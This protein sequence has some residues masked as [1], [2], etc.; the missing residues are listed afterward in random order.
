VSSKKSN[1]K[2]LTTYSFDNSGILNQVFT[3]INKPSGISS[4]DV[5]RK[6][7]KQFDTSRMG[8]LGTLD[9]LA[10]GV[11]AVFIGKGTKIIPYFEEARKTYIVQGE[12]G[13]SSD[14]YDITG[15]VQDGSEYQTPSEDDFKKAITSFLGEQWQIQPAFSA[16]KID[17]KRAYEHAREGKEIDLG[18]RQV[19]FFRIEILE[20]VFPFFR[21]EV[22]CSSGTYV[23]SLIHELGE[24]LGTGAVMTEL[25]RTQAGPFLISDALDLG[26]VSESDLMSLEEFFEKYAEENAALKRDKSYL[27][28]K[29][30]DGS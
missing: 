9:P 28:R 11:L 13:K 2:L 17:G 29:L 18:K 4:Y 10:T 6:L 5:L 15:Q 30:Q 12:L 7:K 1:Y 14:T 27:M 3:I 8:Y 16:L 23:R 19:T 20:S 24:K 22:E 25:Q 26:K 21:L